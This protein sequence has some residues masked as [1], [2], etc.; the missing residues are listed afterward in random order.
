M[1]FVDLLLIGAGLLLSLA[2]ALVSINEYQPFGATPPLAGILAALG[3][4]MLSVFTLR[5]GRRSDYINFAVLILFIAFGRLLLAADFTFARL[6]LALAHIAGL[7]FYARHGRKRRG[8]SQIAFGIA[9]VVLPPLIVW[10]ST[11]EMLIV[12][13]VAGLG[14]LAS[15]SWL[16][17]F[18][19][20]PN[21]LGILCYCAA[22]TILLAGKDAAF[23]TPIMDEGL[24]ILLFLG[25][26]A[27]SIAVVRVFRSEDPR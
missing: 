13:Y 21:G 16:S 8:M 1:A 12:L 15:A 9:L 24:A 11:T 7:A 25:L 19:R 2:S 3:I 22:D 27:A 20:Y 6:V 4:A 10:L 17:R 18:P 26:L 14:A 5:N 23:M